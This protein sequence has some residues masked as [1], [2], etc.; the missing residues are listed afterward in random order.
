MLP[1]SL[2]SSAQFTGAN[3]VTFAV[4]AG[5]GAAFFLVVVN[6]QV[7]LGYSALEAGVALLPVT[8]IM[9]ALSSRMGALAQRIGPRLPM[10]IGPLAVAA[11]LLW[12]GQVGPGDAYVS[13]VLPAAGLFGLGLSITVAP[14]T[15]T[16]LA[17]VD[18]H[19]LGVGSA[20]NNAVARLAGL[21]AV[22][23]LPSAAGVELEI[24]GPDGIAGYGTAMA[25]SAALCVAGAAVAAATIRRATPV[26]TTTQASVLQP[27]HDPCRREA[28]GAGRQL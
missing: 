4:Y 17:A 20:T 9:L 3:L 10:T 5:L 23:V 18:D 12:L 21:L 27:C 16:V 22:A 28:V 8:L 24:V 14:L 25:I 7:A 11:G 1:L 2:F 19:H 15:A 13:A 26:Q 6:L